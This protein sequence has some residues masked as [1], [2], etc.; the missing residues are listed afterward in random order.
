MNSSTHNV[1]GILIVF[2]LTSAAFGQGT[3]DLEPPITASRTQIIRSPDP[4][5][6]PSFQFATAELD[7]Q[8]NVKIAT[9]SATQKMVVPMPNRAA[10]DLDPRGI[11]VVENIE[12]D[13]TVMQKFIETDKNGKEIEVSKP[14]AK[15]RTAPV[16][17]YRKR[18]PEEKVEFEQ[19]LAELKAKRES[20]EIPAPAVLVK[21]DVEYPTTT[22]ESIVDED[23]REFTVRVSNQRTRLSN[24]YRGKSIT[25]ESIETTAYPVA[26]LKC[27]GIDGS[28]LDED[29]IK[30]R[31][32]EQMPVI[33]IPNANAITPFF[34]NMLNPEAMFVVTPKSEASETGK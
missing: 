24:V 5:A 13:Y 19:R 25:E 9:K 16:A 17:R 20:G 7:D 15:V 1:L 27:F 4:D 22:T 3:F 32:A 33:L 30:A 2:C 18:T 8:G 23:G 34:E 12:K 21:V 10:A 11:R 6:L 26:K 29:T 31:L 14:V 28:E